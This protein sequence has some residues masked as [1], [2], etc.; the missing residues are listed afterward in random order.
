MLGGR[1]SSGLGLGFSYGVEFRVR[2]GGLL[3]GASSRCLVDVYF[4]H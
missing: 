1:V 3:S 2:A 4:R